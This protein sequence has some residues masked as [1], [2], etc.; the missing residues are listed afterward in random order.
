MD[1]YKI[2]IESDEQESISIDQ[3]FK[4]LLFSLEKV[5]MGSVK[6]EKEYSQLLSEQHQAKRELAKYHNNIEKAKIE[7]KK[8]V[9]DI[10]KYNWVANIQMIAILTLVSLIIIV[11]F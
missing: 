8:S 3:G 9:E 5:L 2:L 1:L 6:H 4:N 7:E 10:K 11:A